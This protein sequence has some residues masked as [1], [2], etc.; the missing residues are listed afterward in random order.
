MFDKKPFTHINYHTYPG[1]LTVSEINKTKCS[2]PKKSY[3]TL[4]R[5]PTQI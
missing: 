2:H 5:F 1:N 3:S 4:Y